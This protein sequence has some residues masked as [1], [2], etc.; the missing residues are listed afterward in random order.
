M[1]ATLR[2]VSSDAGSRSIPDPGYAFDDGGAD[3][4]LVAAVAA[5]AADPAR[6]PAVL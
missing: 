1:L 5:H 6:L 4:E 3:A 2:P